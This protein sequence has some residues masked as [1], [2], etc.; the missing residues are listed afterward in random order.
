MFDLPAPFLS[1]SSSAI[2]RGS[3][4]RRRIFGDAATVD[5]LAKNP[6]KIR[7]DIVAQN[8]YPAADVILFVAFA[9]SQFQIRVA[10]SLNIYFSIKFRRL[11]LI[12]TSLCTLCVLRYSLRLYV[13]YRI[14]VG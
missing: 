5:R 2:R 10:F 13:S 7:I 1:L 3:L 14:F 12:H 4:C 8:R 9:L 11:K 6:S